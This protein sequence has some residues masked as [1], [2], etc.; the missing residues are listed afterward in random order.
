MDRVSSVGLTVSRKM[1]KKK[2]K[3]SVSRKMA[4]ILTVN[5]NSRYPIETL[6]G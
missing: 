1:A 6:C 2:K 3:N 4:K 5:R